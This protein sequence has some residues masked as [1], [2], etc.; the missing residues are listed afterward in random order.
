VIGLSSNFEPE[1]VDGLR[2]AGGTAH[3]EHSDRDPGDSSGARCARCATARRLAED[4]MSMNEPPGPT[5]LTL[6][7]R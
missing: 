1:I 7:E 3:F 4:V 5:F 6:D 2:R